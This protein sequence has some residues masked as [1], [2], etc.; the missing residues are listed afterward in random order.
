[1]GWGLK[2]GLV[3]RLGAGD[4]DH[5]RET[6]APCVTEKKMKTA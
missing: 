4:V 2:E 5:K 1:M 3:R 6:H